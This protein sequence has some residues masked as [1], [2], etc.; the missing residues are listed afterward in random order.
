MFR[1]AYTEL[2]DRFQRRVCVCQ[3]QGTA[4]VEAVSASKGLRCS[5]LESRIIYVTAGML[6]YWLTAYVMRAQILHLHVVT[7]RCHWRT[8]CTT[9]HQY[10]I[11]VVSRP[12]KIDCVM[13]TCAVWELIS[14]YT[15]ANEG[16]NRLRYVGSTYGET[17][18]E[19]GRRRNT[20]HDDFTPSSRVRNRLLTVAENLRTDLFRSVL[21]L[22]V[23][24]IQTDKRPLV[25]VLR[26]F[27]SA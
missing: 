13:F 16:E 9:W 26:F 24:N 23:V 17:N 1:I 7:A 11:R 19:G 22:C 8:Y 20:T 3:S 2:R 10:Q 27:S 18:H 21:I 4:S 25:R 14:G 12:L 5:E 15:F 6:S